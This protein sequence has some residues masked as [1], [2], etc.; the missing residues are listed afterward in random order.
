MAEPAILIVD[1][2]GAL[3]TM[4]SEYLAQ[5]GCAVEFA[6]DGRSGL[7]AALKPGHDLVILDVMLPVIDGFEVLRQLRRRSRVPVIMLTA[8]TSAEDRIGGLNT[9]ADDYLPKPFNPAELLARIGSVLRRTGK[10]W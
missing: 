7:A 10:D 4:M 8:R 3:C 9:G 1:D 6:H 5:H 2:D